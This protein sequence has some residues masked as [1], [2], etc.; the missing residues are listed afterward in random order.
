VTCVSFVSFVC[1]NRYLGDGAADRHEI[2]HMVELCPDEFFPL[3]VAI[4]LGV[5]KCGVKKGLQVDIFG[6]SNTDFFAI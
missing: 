3:L 4:S 2:F 5:S 6:L 1:W